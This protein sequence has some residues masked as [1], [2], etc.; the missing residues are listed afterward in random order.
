MNDIPQENPLNPVRFENQRIG[1]M[2]LLSE[3]INACRKVGATSV[4][5][6]ALQKQLDVLATQQAK[7][8]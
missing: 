3:L 5:V 1:R 6:E 4:S 7:N 8:V 2:Q